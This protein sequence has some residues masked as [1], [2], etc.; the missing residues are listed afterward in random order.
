MGEKFDVVV[1]GG[2]LSGLVSAM[3]LAQNGMETLVIEKGNY[4]GSK[5][6]TGGRLYGHSMEKVIPGFAETAP[7]ERK[8]TRERLSFMEGGKLST[9]EYESA[10][11]SAPGG[12][13][14]TVLRARF[15]KWLA[16]RAEEAGVMLVNGIRVDDLLMNDG[17]VC[18]IAAGDDQIEA[19]VVILADGVNSLLGQKAG[20][21][22]ELRPDQAV[23]GAKELIELDEKLIEERF[24]LSS[25][26]GMAWM[27]T[28][29]CT[30]D[31]ICD[32]FIYTNRNSLSVGVSMPLQGINRT[33]N[34]VPQMLEDFK[35]LPE[36][37]PLLE[38]GK[39]IEYSA[40]LI[41][42][43]GSDMIPSLYGNGILLVGDA[44]ALT[45]NLGFT[46]RGMDL[47]IESGRLAA[48]AVTAA[49]EQGDF[50]AE[51]LSAYQTALSESFVMKCMKG[52]G[53]C[54]KELENNG[55]KD[56]PLESFNCAMRSAMIV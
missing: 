54:R 30:D 25:G 33:N 24:G 10:G 56:N 12:E 48:E 9:V 53:D 41:P 28:G 3:V 34:S 14:Y 8:V 23:V 15:D 6:M 40:H 21:K 5:N 50:S 27:F 17:K 38:G 36:I 32:G 16:D 55:F 1:V 26:E 39:L 43:G 11:V 46:I 7:V 52:C 45:A 42:E 49:R 44:A 31:G 47:A 20:M 51:S 4:S 18:G 37:A 19:D 2:G 13:S 22:Q 29:C 35:H